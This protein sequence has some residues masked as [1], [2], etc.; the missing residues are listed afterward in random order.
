MVKLYGYEFNPNKV[1]LYAPTD[2]KFVTGLRLDNQEGRVELPHA[3]PHDF[4]RETKRL[5]DVLTVQGHLHHK[6]S[7]SENNLYCFDG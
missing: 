3:F 5:K 6:D 1:M 4:Q 7:P 2:E